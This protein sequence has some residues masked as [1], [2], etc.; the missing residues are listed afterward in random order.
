MQAC[1]REERTTGGGRE[2]EEFVN[3]YKN[4]IM[5]RRRS[6]LIKNL[7]GHDKQKKREGGRFIYNRDC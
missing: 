5:R 1:G 3:L 6:S 4:G 7:K 2:E